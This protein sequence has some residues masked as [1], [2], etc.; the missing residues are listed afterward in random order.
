MLKS[1]LI[2]SL[3]FLIS[4]SPTLKRDIA[5][6]GTY[7][8]VFVSSVDAALEA[9]FGITEADRDNGIILGEDIAPEDAARYDI[10]IE[11]EERGYDILISV[12]VY[13]DDE[14][15]RNST[16]SK[17]VAYLKRLHKNAKVIQAS[18]QVSKE[19]KELLLS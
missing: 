15:A 9:G 18:K 19:S 6:P 12:R 2:L 10:R 5:V 13:S 3:L 17:F 7:N 11:L 16:F 14:Q 4:C 1:S 8:R